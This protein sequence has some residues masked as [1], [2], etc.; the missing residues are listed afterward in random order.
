MA[1]GESEGKEA[2][3][4]GSRR[5][6]STELPPDPAGLGRKGSPSRSLF[7]ARVASTPASNSMVD[8]LPDAASTNPS[9]A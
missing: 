3:A 7:E 8:T 1:R 2:E 6:T 4:A 9:L 5:E